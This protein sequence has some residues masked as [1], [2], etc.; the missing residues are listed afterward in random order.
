MAEDAR[1]RALKEAAEAA[2][3]KARA[4]AALRDAEKKHKE[5]W[6]N[7][8]TAAEEELAELRREAH[9]IRLLLQSSRERGAGEPAR[10]AIEAA[11]RLPGVCRA[12]RRRSSPSRNR[13]CPAPPASS[14]APKCSCRGSGCQAGCSPS[15]TEPSRSKFWAD[16]CVCRSKSWPARRGRRPP[17]GGRRSPNECRRSPSPRR[18]ARCRTSWTCA[19]MR[20]DE[21]LERLEQYLE[22]ASLTG[23]PEARI[24]HG[25]GTGAIRQAVRD[26]LRRSQYVARFT[27]EPDSNGGDGATQ[28]WLK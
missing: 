18:V 20:R 19:G 1:V 28:V 17:N 22:D 15:E 25:K 21:A 26:E 7:A 24:V 16:G 4:R 27:P 3:L 6:E 12:G 11:L 8:Q 5:V 14:L 10:A 23:L 13:R 2:T 9:R